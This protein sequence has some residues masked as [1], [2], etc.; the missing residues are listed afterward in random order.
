MRFKSTKGLC[1]MQRFVVL[2][3]FSLIVLSVGCGDAPEEAIKEE[4]IKEEG[5]KAAYTYVAEKNIRKLPPNIYIPSARDFVEEI[6]ALGIRPKGDFEKSDSYSDE[7]KRMWESAKL[8]G[9]PATGR[10]LLAAEL[11]RKVFYDVDSEI[12]TLFFQNKDFYMDMFEWNF[13]DDEFKLDPAIAKQVMVNPSLP[14]NLLRAAF[15]ISIGIDGEGEFQAPVKVLSSSLKYPF[16]LRPT[17]LHERIVFRRDTGVVLHK[18][19]GK[20]FPDFE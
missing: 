16:E 11:S 1:S 18:S 19:S 8:F 17:V 12:L 6:N 13:N 5:N 9:Q 3:L 14:S 2:V 15:V 20:A 4:A 7:M 10:F